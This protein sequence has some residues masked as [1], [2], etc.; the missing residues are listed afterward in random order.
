MACSRKS[1]EAYENGLGTSPEVVLGPPLKHA[2]AGYITA[3]WPPETSWG[4]LVRCSADGSEVAE[5]DLNRGFGTAFLSTHN[6]PMGR[7]ES[8][9]SG[10]FGVSFAAS[11][12]LVTLVGDVIWPTEKRLLDCESGLFSRRNSMSSQVLKTT[13]CLDCHWQR[14]AVR[15]FIVRLRVVER[16]YSLRRMYSWQN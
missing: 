14:V 2:K 8:A 7:F 12:D 4:W 6:V 16:A 5:I 10:L 3:I 1:R 15:E 13:V 11:N 9:D